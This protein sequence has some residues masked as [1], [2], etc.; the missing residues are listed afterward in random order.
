MPPYDWYHVQP[1]T[2][3]RPGHRIGP[4]PV[5]CCAVER[6]AVDRASPARLSDETDLEVVELAAFHPLER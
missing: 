6:R 4:P 2:E 1:I 3:L 5:G